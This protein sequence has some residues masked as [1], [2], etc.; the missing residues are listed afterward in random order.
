MGMIVALL[1]IALVAIAVMAA[2]AAVIIFPAFFLGL[3]LGA[4]ISTEFYKFMY[5]RFGKDINISDDTKALFRFSI[6]DLIDSFGWRIN[7]VTV[8]KEECREKEK[9]ATETVL[10]VRR[11]VQNLND[12]WQSLLDKHTIKENILSSRKIV[13]TR[14]KK[15]AALTFKDPSFSKLSDELEE[16][17]IKFEEFLA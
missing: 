16:E 12:T 11:G 2:I 5:K 9:K 6:P 4:A 14:I 8:L 10:R 3:L 17:T 7:D 13:S 1:A 15:A